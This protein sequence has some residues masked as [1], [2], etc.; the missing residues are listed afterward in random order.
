MGYGPTN[1]YIYE[2][3]TIYIYIYILYRSLFIPLGHNFTANSHQYLMESPIC[4]GQIHAD[5][6]LL[7]AGE[8]PRCVAQNG[9]CV[10]RVARKVL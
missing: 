9:A 3:I 8:V 6:S 1:S 5:S 2:L 7:L 10:A 4:H